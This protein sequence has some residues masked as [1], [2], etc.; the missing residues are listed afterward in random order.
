MKL[1]R[2]THRG[3]TLA[4]EVIDAATVR[5]PNGSRVALADV[6]L[7]TPC[8]PSKIICVGRNY[9][10][11]ANEPHNT[12]PDQPLL[13]LKPPSAA[14]PSGA[15][16]EYPPYSNF[17]HFEGELAIVVA[18]RCKN[19][20]AYE[21]EK[22]MLGYTAINDITAR[23]A[24]REES[25]WT[26]GKCFDT[27]APLGPWIETDLDLLDVPV[28]TYVNGELRQDGSTRDLVFRVPHLVAHASRVMTLEPGDVIATGTPAG[29]G[30]LRVG[31]TVEVEVGDAGRLSNRVVHGDDA[32]RID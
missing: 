27:S 20:R 1:A 26:R 16:I 29:V 18:R 7:L 28:R 31:D 23:D 19:V 10:G 14:I 13:F 5:T 30:E 17:L 11:H 24:Q 25:Q 12:V 22:V 9:A 4:G 32:Q 8:L 6:T 3:A 21:A 15:E 2:F